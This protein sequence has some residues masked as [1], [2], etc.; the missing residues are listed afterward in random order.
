MALPKITQEINTIKS[1]YLPKSG[2]TMTGVLTVPTPFIIN[3]QNSDREG[4]ELVL[5]CPSSSYPIESRIDN[6]NNETRIVAVDTSQDKVV[7]VV[8]FNHNNHTL[9]LNSNKVITSAGGELLGTL[10]TYSGVPYESRHQTASISDTTRASNSWQ[11]L[12]VG[13]DR[14]GKRGGGIELSY[15][16][17]GSRG[18]YFTMERRTNDGY[19]SAGLREHSNGSSD[20]HVN[21][22]PVIT[23]IAQWRSGTNWYRKYSDGWIEQ[24]GYVYCGSHG[25]WLSYHLPFSD[26][27]Y[28]LNANAGEGTNGVRFVSFYSR[29]TTGAGMYTGDDSSFNSANLYWFACGY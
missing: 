22:Y 12:C 13:L 15:G 18:M 25:T 26:T 6:Y 29:N 8:S 14:D 7:D 27:G 21:G 19:H 17:D 16:T 28:Y 5:K 11:M 4:G 23:L 10:Y 2:G 9:S 1:T 3:S 20:F 24:G